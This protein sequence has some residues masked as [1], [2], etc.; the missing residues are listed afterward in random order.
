MGSWRKSRYQRHELIDGF[1]Q[2][3]LARSRIA[4]V[5]CGA[6]GNEVVKNLVLLGVGEIHLF[7]FDRVEIHNLTRSIF[8]REEDL[9]EQ[10]AVVVARR[11][12]EVDPSV[13]LE[14]FVGDFRMHLGPARLTRY[15]SVI[16]A[17]DNF[18][19]RIELN[20]MCRLA[21]ADLV[22]TGIDSRRVTVERF[23]FRSSPDPA[24]YECHLP[25][26]AYARVAARYSCGGLRRRAMAEKRVP[27]TAI[28]S[29]VA[30]A[31]AV[32]SA[33]RLGEDAPGPARRTFVD[34]VA[35]TSTSNALERNAACP[36][37]GPST[38]RPQLLRVRNRWQRSSPGEITG[39]HTEA[40]RLSEPLIVSCICRNCGAL[41]EI[42][43]FV[44]RPA[45][46]FD[47]SIAR[48]PR[49]AQDSVAFEIRDVFTLEE[50]GARFGMRAVPV[51]YAVTEVNG[52]TICF[53]FLEDMNP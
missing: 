42:A 33:L 46:E 37:C 51:R 10:K 9:G 21:G 34:T 53:D 31:L 8:L 2:D 35:G 41:P 15:D 45:S 48:C 30:G 38:D 25:M 52:R 39:V 26:T 6:V 5:G 22:N 27:T 28:T 1:S 49:C 29:S 3:E 16:A 4:V 11:A 36:T 50:L 24:C 13:R 32:G 17:V 23:P 7:D 14:A 19:A 20:Q 18:E 44:D 47:D 40:I 43:T 12:A